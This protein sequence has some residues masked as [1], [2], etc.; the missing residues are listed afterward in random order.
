MT[1]RKPP[2]DPVPGR[3]LPAATKLFAQKGFDRTT[4]QEIVEVAER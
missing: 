2:E 1:S 4:A 3:L